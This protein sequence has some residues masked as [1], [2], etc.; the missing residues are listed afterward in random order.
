MFVMQRI[1]LSAIVWLPIL[2]A[3]SACAS[4][5]PHPVGDAKP[6]MVEAKKIEKPV[7]VAAGNETP[8]LPLHGNLAIMPIEVETRALAPL[9]AGDDK[10]PLL[11]RGDEK[12][13]PHIALLLPLKS[14]DFGVASEVVRQGFMAA[15]NADAQGLSG[16][17]PVRVYGSFDEG[18]DIV[19]L[20][21]RGRAGGGGAVDAYRRQRAGGGAEY[22]GADSGA[23]YYGRAIRQPVVF[24]RHDGGRGDRKS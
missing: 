23:E 21:R 8:A 14:A 3:L 10:R 13:A 12:P 16:G 6:V 7:A 11:M 15:A 4:T 22:P 20:Y 24:F 2:L 19:A 1:P 5:V 17:L 9:A 18:N